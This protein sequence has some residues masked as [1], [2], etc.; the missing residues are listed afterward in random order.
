MVAHEQMFRD[1]GDLLAH[2]S[3][4]MREGNFEM[5]Q[6]EQQ[7]TAKNELIAMRHNV[8]LLMQCYQEMQA[9]LEQAF[10]CLAHG[11]IAPAEANDV[12]S[13]M[14]ILH[15]QQEMKIIVFSSSV[16]NILTDRVNAWLQSPY[17]HPVSVLFSSAADILRSAVTYSVCIVYREVERGEETCTLEREPEDEEERIERQAQEH[18]EAAARHRDDPMF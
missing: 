7:R 4:D 12:R 2:I 14:L 15:A 18:L 13:T 11:S 17:I 3:D 6:S 5:P 8:T 1:A 16:E 9:T 10:Q